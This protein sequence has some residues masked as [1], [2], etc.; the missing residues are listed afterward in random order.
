[1]DFGLGSGIPVILFRIFYIKT[2]YN[3]AVR[4]SGSVVP[5]YTGS[6]WS[7]RIAAGRFWS[8]GIAAG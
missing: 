4:I 3:Y 7:T 8:T 2:V 5:N 6:T 1:M